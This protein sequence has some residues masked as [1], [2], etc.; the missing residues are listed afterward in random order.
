[1]TRFEAVLR[2]LVVK[3][4]F[5]NLPLSSSVF[6][7]NVNILKRVVWIQILF[8]FF[9]RKNEKFVVDTIVVLLD[10]Y[11]TINIHQV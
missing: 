1:M 8:F 3:L 9:L 6:S 11:S 2:N 4:W 7:V 10:I 5:I